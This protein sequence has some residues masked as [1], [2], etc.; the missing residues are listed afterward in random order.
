MITSQY[1]GYIGYGSSD[2]EALDSCKVISILQHEYNIHGFE[3][4]IMRR[5]ELAPWN[6][7]SNTL[8]ISSIGYLTHKDDKVFLNNDSYSITTLFELL[9][10]L[11]FDKM[12]MIDLAICAIEIDDFFIANNIIFPQLY[13]YHQVVPEDVYLLDTNLLAQIITDKYT[14]ILFDTNKVGIKRNEEELY[15]TCTYDEGVSS[16]KDTLFYIA[17]VRSYELITNII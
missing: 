8:H 4:L 14:V 2:E 5:K 12:S 16:I 6:P 17:Y 9:Y 7:T 13:M 11:L 15:W 1:N 10:L 3:D